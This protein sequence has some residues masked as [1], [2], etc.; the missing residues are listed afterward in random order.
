MSNKCRT[1]GHIGS[2]AATWHK[3][4]LRCRHVEQMSNKRQKGTLAP[5]PPRVG[6][7]S[8]RTSNQLV[9]AP[10]SN[11]VGIFQK[12]PTPKVYMY[13]TPTPPYSNSSTNPTIKTLNSRL[14]SFSSQSSVRL[15]SA[16]IPI[17]L[18]QKATI[19]RCRSKFFADDTM[20]SRSRKIYL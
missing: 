8:Q 19:A 15:R 13:R 18:F 12:Y 5:V 7:H 16:G 9:P 1:K 11:L 6:E 10:S 17:H 20:T 3:H 2:G 4:W 14:N